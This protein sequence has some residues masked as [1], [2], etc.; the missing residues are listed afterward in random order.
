MKKLTD[1]FGSHFEYLGVDGKTDERIAQ[2]PMFGKSIHVCEENSEKLD[3]ASFLKSGILEDT[4]YPFSNEYDDIFHDGEN[5]IY[6]K[7]GKPI[8][9]VT[10]SKVTFLGVT[11][12]YV[13]YDDVIMALEYWV[14]GFGHFYLKRMNFSDVSDYLNVE[15]HIF[16]KN[17]VE[18]QDDSVCALIPKNVRRKLELAK[19]DRTRYE[20]I[21]QKMLLEYPVLFRLGRLARYKQSMGTG[22]YGCHRSKEDFTKCTVFSRK[23]PE[24]NH[25][26]LVRSDSAALLEFG[27]I[28]EDVDLQKLAEKISEEE[29]EATR[30]ALIEYCKPNGITKEMVDG[31]RLAKK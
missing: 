18:L 11:A 19:E 8:M 28:G 22:Y 27:W 30:N 29:C 21:I 7:D 15:A 20:H 9:I 16:D 2:N 4:D 23:S 17:G 10:P 13:G 3:I 24:R 26:I 5:D 31:I 12:G 1:T 6:L 25:P 14:D